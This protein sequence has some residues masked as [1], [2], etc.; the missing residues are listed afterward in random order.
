MIFT[1]ETTKETWES[2]KRGRKPKWVSD[3]EKEGKIKLP[4]KN[5]IKADKI[6]KRLK[7]NNVDTNIT[8]VDGKKINRVWEWVG[9]D[10][11]PNAKCIIIAET[12]RK[13]IFLMNKTTRFPVSSAEWNLWWKQKKINNEFIEFID[14]TKEQVLEIKDGVWTPRK[15]LTNK[16][17]IQ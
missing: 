14:I 5:V 11:K 7:I 6:D 4:E 2:G 13:A 17:N 10:G 3:Y 12:S 15:E 8:V 1:N 9:E 16:E